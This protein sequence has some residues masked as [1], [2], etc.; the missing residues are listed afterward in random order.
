MST[1]APADTQTIV[2]APPQGGGLWRDSVR[3]FTNNRVAVAGLVGVVL[4]VLV[5]IFA[6]WI[7]FTP[8]DQANLI[9]SL[10]PPSAEHPLGTD[11]VGRDFFSRMVW[12]ARTSVLV[13]FAAASISMLIGLPLGAL[14]GWRGGW[15]DAVVQ[16]IVE[17]M[18]AVPSLLIA[19]LLVS[20]YGG[21]LINVILFM[22]L[23]G[24]VGTL[25]LARGQFLS[26]RERE[27]VTAARALGV[28][29]RRIMV[30]HVLTNA[31]GPILLG[32][33]MSIPGAMFG[34]AG[35]SFLGFGVN[36]PIPSWG[37]MVGEGAQYILAFQHLAIFPT[38]AL[39][40]TI[41]SFSFVADGLRDAIDPYS[42]R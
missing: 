30:R 25:R 17:M 22:G 34:E 2:S 38:I 3:R 35:L 27:F 40:F 1:I 20:I 39:A 29:E 10:K 33:A 36:D 42:D 9:E 16:R 26:L 18:T 11:P 21:G 37:K 13:G 41:L 4:V 8:Y 23:T 12:G 7:A 31:A 32:F 14:A 6:P 15:I 28:S 5:A 24:W 19:L